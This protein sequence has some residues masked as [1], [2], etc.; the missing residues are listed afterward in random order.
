[1]R[2]IALFKAGPL[3]GQKKQVPILAPQHRVAMLKQ[4]PFKVFDDNTPLPCPWDLI[5]GR[6]EFGYRLGEAWA[7][8]DGEDEVGIYVPDSVRWFDDEG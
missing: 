1:M 4:A 7:S 8:G 6:G 3:D 2:S 5:P